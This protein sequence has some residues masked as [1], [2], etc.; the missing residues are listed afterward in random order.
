MEEEKIQ[1]ILPPGVRG[2]K[3]G[4]G[5]GSGVCLALTLLQ[6]GMAAGECHRSAAWAPGYE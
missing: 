4:R 6:D 5:G 1:T 2:E 3:M